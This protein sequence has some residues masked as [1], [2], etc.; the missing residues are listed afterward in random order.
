LLDSLLQEISVKDNG[1]KRKEKKMELGRSVYV[2]ESSQNGFIVEVPSFCND[3][4]YLVVYNDD[5]AAYLT[6][7]MISEADVPVMKGDHISCLFTD[8]RVVVKLK[9]GDSVQVELN[10]RLI[11]AEIE[12]AD[13]NIATVSFPD[14]NIEDIYLGS[15]RFASVRSLLNTDQELMDEQMAEEKL[16]LIVKAS[17]PKVKPKPYRPHNCGKKCLPKYLPSIFRKQNPLLIPLRLGWAREASSIGDDIAKLCMISYVAPCGLR[18]RTL[19]EVAQLLN[20]CQSNLHIDFFNF[21]PWVN[22]R[23]EYVSVDGKVEVPDIT[24][25]KEVD[26]VPAINTI[27]DQPLPPLDYSVEAIPQGGIVIPKDPEFLVCCSCKD[28]C[29]NREKCECIQLT[30][31]GTALDA[32][33][34]IVL[35]DAGYEN[36]RL[37]D[38]LTTGIFECN[39]RCSC[40]STCHN[41]VS[42]QPIRVQLQVFKTRDRGWGIRSLHDIPQGTFVSKYVGNLYNSVLGN[43]EGMMHGDNYFCELDLIEN[44]EQNKEGYES[45]VTDIEEE[46]EQKPKV[47]GIPVTT[48]NYSLQ[49]Q[50]TPVTPEASLQVLSTPDTHEVNVSSPRKKWKSTRKCFKDEEV[51]L[52]DAMKAGN[53]GRFLNHSCDPNVFIQNVFHD[54]HDLRFPTVAFYTCKFVRAGEELCWN[55][56]YEV[57]SVPGRRIDCFCGSA[58][59][60]KRLL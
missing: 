35:A 17:V 5:T 2:A 39:H 40:S 51:Y 32:E 23:D 11:D 57:D 8:N 10:G 53:I 37:K 31:K 56:G 47:N 15:K 54:T 6:K 46:E 19:E 55:Y 58:N 12:S 41:R 38:V 43:E 18:L 1:I 29:R 48:A 22:V 59:C 45:D 9:A 25:G 14:G 3:W 20:S 50:S 52:V 44:V 26:P 33:G 27:D 42:Q 49:V 4:R 7:D 36:R 21:D 13:H 60:K 28:N 16:G 34:E 30:I 24:E